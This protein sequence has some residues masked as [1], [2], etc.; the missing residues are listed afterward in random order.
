MTEN[1]DALFSCV[2]ICKEYGNTRALSEVSFSVGKGEI[3]GLVG[4][5]GA[6]KST[7]MK[8]M[9]GV[10]PPTAGSMKMRGAAYAPRS[11]REANAKGMGMVFQEQSLITNLTVAQ[12]LFFGEEAKYKKYGVI[13]WAV[14]NRDARKIL[15]ALA[16]RDIHENQRVSNIQFSRR[17]MIEIAKVLGR[18][19]G[20]AADG[21]LILLD[22]PT[23]VLSGEEVEILFEEMRK[24]KA[25]GNGVV[26]ISHRLDE[27][28]RI[29]DK[30]VVFKDGESV[31][32]L[33]GN[34]ISEEAIFEK[35]IGKSSSGEF[36]RINRQRQPEQKVLIEAKNLELFG[37]FK[38]V[39]FTLRTGEIVGI[40]G[41]VGSG[42]EQ[43]C[44]VLAGDEKHT[45]GELIVSG[46]TARFSSPGEALR[47]SISNVPTERRVDGQVGIATVREN[48]TYSSI[49]NI[50]VMGFISRKKE[51]AAVV[52]WIQK[53]KIKC[54]SSEQP[55][56]NLS[57]GNAQKVVFA[58][59]LSGDTDVIILNHP[60]R[61]VDVGAK[62]EIYDIIRDAAARGKGVI[63]LGDTLE[64]CIGLSNKILVMKD[65]FVT[66]TI[67][68]P[69]DGKPE[70]IEILQYMM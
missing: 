2:G 26:F 17:Q 42:K 65:G 67:D 16:L 63:L 66:R 5:N 31:A 1:N 48:I 58:R 45:K 15:D 35:M 8:I 46:R 64:E 50:S 55:I 13:N 24:L 29:S 51:K 43:L 69:K 61:G 44:S 59:V 9:Q 27:V 53:L 19:S 25:G 52:E 54:E 34:E 3:V 11:A 32:E 10:E 62:E 57:G 18:A 7:L 22:E 30:I 4:E 20:N 70:Q 37:F 49:R 56:E 21:A 14:M 33:S 41:V 38:N 28:I 40:Y 6:G 68:A 36:Y 47:R 39:N 23:S 60:T 12:N